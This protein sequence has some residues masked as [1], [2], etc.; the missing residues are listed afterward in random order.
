MDKVRVEL[1]TD[2]MLTYLEPMK[3]RDQLKSQ[4]GMKDGSINIEL[5]SLL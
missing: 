1:I 3:K 2:Q 5:K 4:N